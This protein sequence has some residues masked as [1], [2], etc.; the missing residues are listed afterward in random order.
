MFNESSY[1]AYKQYKD[2]LERFRVTN[3]AVKALY[4]DPNL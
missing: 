2:T 3:L 4:L 1:R